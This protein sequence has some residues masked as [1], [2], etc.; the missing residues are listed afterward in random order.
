MNT[1]FIF[2]LVI[3]AACAV[4]EL[5]TM[6]LTSIWFAV[7]ALVAAI[8]S[9][10]VPY[11]WV[12]LVVFVVV[13]VLLLVFTKPIAVK[14]LNVGKFKSNA[15]SLVGKRAIVTSEIDNLKEIGEVTVSGLDWSARTERDGVVIPKNAVVVIKKIEGVKL[16][17]DLDESLKEVIKLEESDAMLNPEMIEDQ[18]D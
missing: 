4:V 16:I 12:Q 14:F 3:V 9:L 1:Q 11:F 8:C 17:V 15:E 2:W 18:D 7:G 13:S 6:G 5:L 10:F